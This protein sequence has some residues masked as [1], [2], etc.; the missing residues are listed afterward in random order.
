MEAGSQEPRA[1]AAAAPR[2]L[3]AGASMIT[4]CKPVVWFKV[5]VCSSANSRH[6][7]VEGAREP[8]NGNQWEATHLQHPLLSATR[9]DLAFN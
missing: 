2:G 9:V 3:G 8:G 4:I 6:L 5:P 1:L 7:S